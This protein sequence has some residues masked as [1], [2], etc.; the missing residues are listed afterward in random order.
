MKQITRRLWC[1]TDI[2]IEILKGEIA[3]FLGIFLTVGLI[4]LNE[5][6][7]KV[8]ECWEGLQVSACSGYEFRHPG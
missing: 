2:W 1:S 7:K 6:C 5:M 3:E 8:F 4:F